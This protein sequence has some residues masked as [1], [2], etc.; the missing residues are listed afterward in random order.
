[1]FKDIQF[2]SYETPRPVTSMNNRF[3]GFSEDV[4]EYFMPDGIDPPANI[5]NT[6]F[7]IAGKIEM[8]RRP[9][10]SEWTI[11]HL[12]HMQNFSVFQCDSNFFTRRYDY[13]SYL[14]LFTYDGNGELEYGNKKYELGP[15]DGFFI[16]CRR[17]HLYRTKGKIWKHSVLHFNGPLLP[18]MFDLFFEHD[19]V[20]FSQKIDGSYQERLETILRMY[21]SAQG[22]KDWVISDLFSRLLT[23]NFLVTMVDS[24]TESKIPSP[25]LQVTQYLEHHFD[26]HITLDL[27]SEVANLSKFHLSREFKKYIGFTPNEYLI[28]L[29]IEHAKSML[30]TTSL[31]VNKIANMVGITDINNF[32]NLFKKRMGVTPKQ[33][34][35]ERD[36]QH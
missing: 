10:L 26:Q 5:R 32:M 33:Y 27:L 22:N 8:F 19:H 2:L 30:N 20:K 21:N 24:A 31:P 34:R 36:K 18:Y 15:G 12:Y 11:E 16:D 14:I 3:T 7:Y 35:N 29:R 23:E 6:D 4:V 28:Q 9:L 25:I 1:M 13:D 17:P